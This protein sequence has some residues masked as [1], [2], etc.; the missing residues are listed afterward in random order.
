MEN[1]QRNRGNTNDRMNQQEERQNQQNDWNNESMN[2]SSGL[3][4]QSQRE[5]DSSGSGRSYDY[6][7]EGSN[8][9]DM[10]QQLGRNSNQQNVSNP[11]TTPGSGSDNMPSPGR[12]DSRTGKGSGLTTKQSTTG[13]DFDGQNRTS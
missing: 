9:E 12:S 13:S 3:R 4:D 8:E 5:Q 7:T 1:N 6:G 10:N 11:T 2:T